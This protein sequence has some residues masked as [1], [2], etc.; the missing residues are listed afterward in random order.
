M[1]RLTAERNNV[2]N[3]AGSWW[4]TPFLGARGLMAILGSALLALVH[5][6]V[7]A[8]VPFGTLLAQKV[9]TGTSHSCA[10]TIDGAV[11]CWGTN[12]NGQLGDSTQ[13]QRTIPVAVTG[14]GTGAGAT[15]LVSGI[16]HSCV[17][18][19]AG[20]VQCWGLN[21]NGQLGDNTTTQRLAPVTVTGLGSG[22]GV[23]ALAAGITHT[24][25]LT[26]AGSV[27]CWGAN[28]L[29]QLGDNTTTQRLTPAPVSGLSSGVTAIVARSSHTCAITS[30]GAVQCWGSNGSGQLGDNSTTTRLT[31]VAVTGLTSGVTA[32]AVAT[33]HSC[34]VTSAGG[35]QCW[36]NNTA[37]ELGDTTTTP[38]LTPVQV[39]G[40][41]AG[42]TAIAA[43]GGHTCVVANGGAALCWG[44]NGSG[45]LGD[46][47]TTVRTAPVPVAG[48][49]SGVRAF[50]AAGSFTC[51]VTTGAVVQ[52]WGSNSNGQL[53]DNTT[54]NRL[55]A[56]PVVGLTAEITAVAGG[57]THTCAI[58]NGGAHCWGT[59]LSGQS[60]DG[61][62]VTRAT[63]QAVSGLSTGVTALT[64]GSDFNCALSSDGTVQC[65]GNNAIG[66][67]G[68]G[69]T[70]NR[71]APVTNFAVSMMPPPLGI[72]AGFEHAC[73]VINSAAVSCWGK[74][75]NGQLGDNTFTNRLSPV[76]V[77]NLFGVKA[78]AAGDDHTC[79]LKIDG[80]VACWGRNTNGQL[81]DN[82]TIDRLTPVSVTGLSG[83][84]TAITAG[85]DN[86]CALTSAGAVQ[87]WGGNSLG[88]LGDSSQTQRLTPV[89]VTGLTTGV[90][91]IAGKLQHNCALIAGGA[92]KC[93]GRNLSGQLGDNSTLSRSAP[94]A[95]SGLTAGATAVGVGRHHSCAVAA[96]GTL[97]C[98]G[99]NG[100]GR[101]GDNTVTSRLTPVTVI[102]LV[103]PDAPFIGAATAGNGF[104]SVAFSA[105]LNNGG[106]GI[107]SYTAQC[108]TQSITGA[109]SPLVVSGLTNGVSVTCTVRAN[110]GVGAGVT[111]GPSNAVTPTGPQTITFGPQSART[112]GSPF[113]LSPLATASSSLAVAYSSTTTGVCTVNASTG[114]VTMVTTGT[115]TIAAD[116]PGNAAFTAA[117]Q[118]TQ[119]FTI[120]PA[121]QA[122]LAVTLTPSTITLGLGQSATLGTTGGNG[123]GAVTYA[124]TTNPGNC[125]IGGAGDILT[126]TAVGSCVVTATKAADLNYLAATATLNV[127]TS[128]AAQIIT[129]GTA[130]VVTVGGTGS[131]AASGGGSGNPVIFTSNTQAICT[132]SGVNGATVTGVAQGSC[133]IVANQ[134][135]DATYSAATPVTQTF[136]IGATVPSSVTPVIAAGASHS[137]AVRADGSLWAWGSN[138]Q[139]Q[140]GD[141]TTVQRNTRVQIGI[142]STWRTVGAGDLHSMAVRN[143]GTLWTWGD[144]SVGQ[145]GDGTTV[146]RN[147][148]VQVGSANTWTAVEG[149]RFHSL[150]LRA[151]GTLWAW[152][153]NFFGEVGDGSQTDRSAPVQVGTATNWTAIAAG[154]FHS[155]AVRADGTLWA[156][157]R[158]SE[159][160]LGDG[161]VTQRLAPVQVGTASNWTAVVATG[162]FSL[163]L[164]ADGTLWGWGFNGNFQLGDGTTAQRNSPVQIGSSAAWTALGAGAA[165]SLAIRADGSLWA[166]GSNVNGQ[167]GDGTVTTRTTPIQS[168][169]VTTWVAAAGTNSSSFAL[170]ADGT[171]WS[172]GLNSSGQLGDGTLTSRTLPVQ[173]GAPGAPTIGTATAGNAQASVSFT[174]PGADGGSAITSYTA[175]SNPGLNTGTCTAPCTSIMVNG[176]TNGTAYTFTVTA[177]NNFGAGALSAPSNSVT[178]IAIQ[179]QTVTFNPASP[180]NVGVGPITLTATAS[181]GLTTFNFSTGSAA[182]ICTVSGNQ[183]TIVGAGTCDLTAT[184][185]GNASYS[186]ASANASV[187]IN[188]QSQTV[189][190]TPASPVNVGVSP[191]TLT[192][193]ASSGLTAFTFST[194]SV[195]G[196]CTVSGN[197]L[198]IVGAGTCDLTATQAGNASYASASANASVVVNAVVNPVLTAVLSRKTHGSAGD[199][200]L[201]IDTS[202]IAPAVT[203]EPRAIGAGHT[204]VFQFSGPVNAAGTASVSPAGTA[205]A[206]FSGN[207]VRV[208]LTNVADNQRVTVTLSG[209][210]GSLNPPSVSIGFLVGDVNNT[211][212]VNPADLSAIRAR[213]GQTVDGSN[214]R[215]DLN[216]SG[217]VTASD[218]AAVKARQG[219]AL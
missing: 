108:G 82:T 143:D 125:S 37:G 61:T 215:F 159:G 87:C 129:F 132:V 128:L 168:G 71:L 120:N 23:I 137:L 177:A 68:D 22:S 41:T 39:S 34:A 210:N 165:H 198:T 107:T 36:G 171:V 139:G 62:G 47:T 178:P 43:A 83:V 2:D 124:V 16:N 63:P 95:V 91:A 205:V 211:R 76:S 115:C 145:L 151:D 67:L 60:G 6:G 191:I 161:T 118:V 53:G 72:A 188:V 79:A 157:G 42:V 93:W 101:L 3:A 179:S 80:T 13:T 102:S 103:A 54:T 28:N 105:P 138:A 48:L 8:Q 197:Q 104:V 27:Q 50:A 153:D 146:Q 141:G 201:M 190:F 134:A 64:S 10:L 38:R 126:A 204:I 35:V 40:L 7:Q 25:A 21:S 114:L 90:T 142:G 131:V 185:A 44:G 163:A 58:A 148:P 117:P 56:A 66:Q 99:S 29:G 55:T 4:Q 154:R 30:G 195:A 166:W 207:E 162:D 189:T 187:V 175:T 77:V 219:R 218:I 130:P 106:T 116:Q 209:V 183:L 173:I 203:V 147:A 214:W 1:R 18:T 216:T 88:Q 20:A 217:T 52:C 113:T 172:W 181:S 70:I 192:A 9:A 109:G 5:T 176:L 33:A 121:S 212:S 31:P 158:N 96:D 49:A 14:L 184:Q 156:W 74:N 127:T 100:S 46:G 24:C 45:Q 152:G 78:V 180:V 73:A 97:Q 196:I 32:I 65:W 164:R 213:A 206:A 94:V 155:L 84:V 112:Y 122:A 51:A 160:Q 174:A 119:S 199:F 19:S 86:T 169:T 89:T 57:N 144:N 98:W 140:L 69:T 110:S 17:V 208:A 81:G 92:V 135:G 193:T 75:S 26:A 150:A 59:N 194:T 167:L 111:S 123:T 149:G 136:P 85:N 170:R 12:A 11:Y 15:A 200:E 186:S 182:G 202:L 133:T